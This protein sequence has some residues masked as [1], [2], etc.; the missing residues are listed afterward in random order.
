MATKR[1]IAICMSGGEFATDNDGGLL[2][3]KGGD[4]YAMDL[5]QDTKLKDLKE[6]LAETFNCSVNRMLIK[7]FLPG[8][9]NKRTL[10]TISKDKDLKRLVNIFED[11]D[12]VEFFVMEEEAVQ[13]QKVLKAPAS[14]DIPVLVVVYTF[15]L[16]KMKLMEFTQHNAPCSLLCSTT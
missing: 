14:R 6:E 13:V 1:I 5:D 12:Q 2:S 16:P 7:Y 15:H 9:S 8:K 11:K 10:I 3:Y 4:A